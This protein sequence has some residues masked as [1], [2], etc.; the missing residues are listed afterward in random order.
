MPIVVKD[1]LVW[2]IELLPFEGQMVN[3]QKR[4]SANHSGSKIVGYLFLIFRPGIAS[5]NKIPSSKQSRFYLEWQI[6]PG[7]GP[8]S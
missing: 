4:Y 8:V 6:V 1:K 3:H 5:S 7:C 2:T